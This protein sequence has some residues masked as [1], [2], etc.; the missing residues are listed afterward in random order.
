MTYTVIYE[1][2]PS[3]WGAY[4]PDLP[5]VVC[6]GDSKEEVEQLMREAVELHFETMRGLGQAIPEPSCFA[7]QVE[8]PPAA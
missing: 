7:G 2:G 6:V 5:G 4:I 1:R 3:T 8:I